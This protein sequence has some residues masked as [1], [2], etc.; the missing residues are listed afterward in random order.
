MLSLIHLLLFS[1]FDSG[2]EDRV[3]LDRDNSS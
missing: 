2:E 1:I 3:I